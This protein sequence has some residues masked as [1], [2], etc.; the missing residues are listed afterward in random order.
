MK[1]ELRREALTAA[2]QSTIS[3]GFSAHAEQLDAPE[4][5]KHTLKWLGFDETGNLCVVL[6]ADTLWDWMYIDELWVDENSR[7]EGLGRQLMQL[8][9]TQAQVEGLAGIWLWTQS[10]QAEDFYLKLGYEEFT[11]FENFPRG[12]SRIGFRKSLT[13]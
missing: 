3:T 10:W 12:H 8:A 2:E 9:E 1:I 13:G 7:G 11:R 6:T 5:R 4:Y